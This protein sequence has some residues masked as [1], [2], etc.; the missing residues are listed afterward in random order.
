M[1]TKRKYQFGGEDNALNTV[2]NAY[3][4]NYMQQFQP[5]EEQQTADNTDQTD[6]TDMTDNPDYNELLQK[7]QDLQDR[8][9][10][11]DA[12]ISSQP[13]DMEDYGDSFLNF[14]FSDNG[15]NDPVDWGGVGSMVNGAAK[16]IGQQ[17]M[18]PVSSKFRQFNSYEAGKN[19]L[20]NQLRLYQTGKTRTGVKPNFTLLQAM[21]VYAPP[22]ENDT[23]RYANFIA[24]KLGVTTDTPISQI[25]THKWA[26]AIA[27]FE[28][29]K[30]NNPGNLKRQTG[31]F[32]LNSVPDIKTPKFNLNLPQVKEKNSPIGGYLEHSFPDTY[33]GVYANIPKTPLSIGINATGT[34]GENKLDFSP[35]LSAEYNKGKNTF[36]AEYFPGYAGINYTRHFQTGGKYKVARTKA[37]QHTGLN[38]SNYNEMS[39]PMKGM[40]MFRGLDNHQ[41][42]YMQDQRGKKAVLTHPS[43]MA[44][45]MGNVTEKRLK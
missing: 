30:G 23:N 11:Q 42:V 17:A 32:S 15:N 8:Y 24:H 31:G 29:N 10:S 12:A 44:M 3:K 18:A 41:P 1:G 38:D 14:I 22:H 5:Q 21:S 19:A 33:A 27:Q 37:E 28:G 36:N 20:V 34:V 45:M 16:T 43:Q 25:D 7:Y 26:D 39:F 4:Q 6:Q 9:G 2:L 35:Y 13:T 40:N